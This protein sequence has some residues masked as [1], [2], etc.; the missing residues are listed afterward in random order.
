MFA[1]LRHPYRRRVLTTLAGV[2]PPD[3]AA[4]TPEDVHTGDED[5]DQFRTELY[6]A[7]L[8]K[9]TAAGYIDWD[10]A[11]NTSHPGPNFE[12]IAPVLRLMHDH[13]DELPGGWP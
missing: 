13:Q 5:V 10:R 7:H 4:L 9:L 8:P 11:T 12:E 1:V 6:H 2:T 3:D